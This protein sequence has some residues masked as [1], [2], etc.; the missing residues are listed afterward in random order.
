MALVQPVIYFI[1]FILFT[2]ILI[3]IWRRRKLY[4]L[5]WQLPGPVAFPLIGNAL[6]FMCKEEDIFEQAINVTRNYPQS[7][8]RFWLGPK[9]IVLFQHV[10]HAERIMTSTN[11]LT[12]DPIYKFMKTFNGEGLITGSGDKW[13]RDR[14]L[15]SPI[16]KF[17]FVSQYFPI[18]LDKSNRLVEKLVEEIDKPTF[19]IRLYL[20]RCVADYV[21]ETILGIPLNTLEGEMDVFLKAIARTY[22]IIHA[23][24]IKV[25]LQIEWIFRLTKFHKEQEEA[26]DIYFDVIKTAINQTRNRK[27]RQ[28]ETKKN[29]ISFTSFILYLQEN[30]KNYATDKEVVHH[31]STIFSASEDTITV[32]CSFALVLFGMYPNIQNKVVEELEEILGNSNRDIQLEDIEKLNYLEMCIKDVLRLFPI[33]PFIMRMSSKAMRIECCSCVI[34][35]YAIHRDTNLWKY[36]NDFYPEHF[37]PQEVKKRH[38]FAFLP[39]SGGLRS[40][41]G[42]QYAFLSMKTTL[43]TV[44]RNFI[45]ESDGKLADKKLKTDISVRFKDDLYPVRIKRRY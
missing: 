19:D 14:K 24:I 21:S 11:F 9:L 10:A 42:R 32:I 26:K 5:S 4:I 27:G 13:K 44:L 16:F 39:F 6:V 31:L 28:E 38:N 12:K 35:I 43:A 17:E 15:M 37:L 36:P 1:I 23:R 7:P 29:N 45:I 20:H 2:L 18:I 41:L 30:H 40:C 33:A 3:N 8:I 22:T 25:W 34:N